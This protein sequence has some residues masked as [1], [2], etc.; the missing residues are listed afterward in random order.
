MQQHYVSRQISS[1]FTRP[2]QG[3]STAQ[4]KH[5]R[6]QLKVRHYHGTLPNMD[7]LTLQLQMSRG[8]LPYERGEDARRLA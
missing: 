7:P 2:F 1:P 6:A 4:R 8:G 3:L 5:Q